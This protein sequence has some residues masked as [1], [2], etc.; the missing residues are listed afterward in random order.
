MPVPRKSQCRKRRHLQ[1]RNLRQHLNRNDDRSRLLSRKER[2]QNA[3]QNVDPDQQIEELR[4]QL[5]KLLNI[6]SEINDS[7]LLNESIESTADLGSLDCPA[8][9]GAVPFEHAS[10]SFI[11]PT[12]PA[13]RRRR[14]DRIGSRFGVEET[15][16]RN[17]TTKRGSSSSITTSTSSSTAFPL[18]VPQ[19]YDHPPALMGAKLGT[20]DGSTNMDIYL[21]KFR[22]CAEYFEWN[23]KDQLFQLKHSLEGAA[24]LVVHKIGRDCTLDELV[25]VLTVQFGTQ[26]SSERY[27]A[28]MRGRRR[29]PNESLQSLYQDL[30]RL[31]LLAFGIGPSNEFSETYLRDIFVDA[32]N[33]LELR[34]LI[35]LQK[36]K[37]MEAALRIASRIEAIDISSN[38]IENKRQY[39]G[40]L[41]VRQQDNRLRT[42]EDSTYSV[43]YD[44]TVKR[45]LTEMR[46]ALQNVRKELAQQRKIVRPTQSREQFERDNAQAAK[47]LSTNTTSSTLDLDATAA[48]SPREATSRR[49]RDQER[50]AGY[51]SRACYSC[52]STNHLA[53]ECPW[54]LEN[55]NS[56]WNAGR[57]QHRNLEH[58]SS[59]SLPREGETRRSLHRN[60][61][62]NA[63]DECA[64]P[65]ER[66]V[67]YRMRCQRL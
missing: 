57:K 15:P 25:S 18:S 3:K 62:Q 50:I 55:T 64:A 5:R 4:A 40:D 56:A 37:T 33:D 35:L 22:I 19:R 16:K 66:A 17:T 54:N 59:A 26:L 65:D 14:E 52:N 53:R 7:F 58:R 41:G 12:P 63:P 20:Y 8:D 34:K 42:V 61:I 2:Q 21:A 1:Q 28:E 11:A 67:G 27:R 30:C 60:F 23:N 49:M 31:K 9:V 44:P 43:D 39:Q 36:P 29:H 47:L 51:G 38:V 24:V 48:T 10:T 13:N 45:Q 46:R 6:R 32:L